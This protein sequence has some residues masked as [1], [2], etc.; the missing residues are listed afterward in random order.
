MSTI[1]YSLLALFLFIIVH[2]AFAGGE[3]LYMPRDIRRAYDRGT[4]AWNGAPGAKYWQNEADYR[5]RATVMPERRLLQGEATIIYRNNAPDTLRQL[6]LKLHQNMNRKGA[7]R[8][9]PLG[10]RA[11][12]EGMRISAL[13]AD[14]ESR[15]IL[16]GSEEAVVDGGNL[17][18]ALPRPLPTGGTV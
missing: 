1:R 14:G 15:T 2:E 6:V 11:V 18:V 9:S 16:P 8:L 12:T 10:E 3:G 7:A 5:I 17:T 4:R 13:T